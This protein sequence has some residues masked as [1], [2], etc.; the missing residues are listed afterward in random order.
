MNFPM[1]TE[2]GLMEKFFPTKFTYH[3][4]F[5]SPPFSI[6]SNPRSQR[7]EGKGH[8]L[9]GLLTP[10]VLLSILNYNVENIYETVRIEGKILALSQNNI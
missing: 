7:Q 3:G 9:S 5:L 8:L 10:E 4:F 2:M 6:V 1:A